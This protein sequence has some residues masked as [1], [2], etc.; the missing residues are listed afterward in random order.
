VHSISAPL[1]AERDQVLGMATVATQPQ[2]TMLETTALEVF[3]KLLLHIPRQIRAL[4]RQARR[5]RGI[6]FLDELIEEGP[7]R[8][9]AHI[10]WRTDTRTGFPASRR[11]QHDRILAIPSFSASA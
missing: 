4:R 8:A 3:L 11:R 7:L 1:A 6:V 9:V 5:E 10:Q 2:E